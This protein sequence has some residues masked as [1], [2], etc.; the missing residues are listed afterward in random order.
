MSQEP[1]RL[2]LKLLAAL[3]VPL[4]IF[5]L[6]EVALRLSPWDERLGPQRF[7]GLRESFPLFWDPN[8]LFSSQHGEDGLDASPWIKRVKLVK[9][10]GTFRV[11]SLGG[12]V[13]YGWP[14]EKTPEA[15]YPMVLERLLNQSPPPGIRRFEVINAGVAAFS[16]YQGLE[17]F[18][19]RLRRYKPDLVTIC[20]GNND[21]EN[22]S[23]TGTFLTDREYYERLRVLA[24]KKMIRKTRDMLNSLRAYALL[25]KAVFQIKLALFR[26]QHRVPP[27]EFQR[28]LAEFLQMAQE[29]GFKLMLIYEPMI[30]FTD[31]LEDMSAEDRNNPYRKAM[32][33]VAVSSPDR[34]VL[35]NSVAFFQ[36]HQ[37]EGKKLF[38]DFMHM[39]KKGNRLMAGFLKE[40]LIKSDF[41]K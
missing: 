34:V 26:D 15:A 9:P 25:E 6:L 23:E 18:K 30:L 8:N 31:P 3:C 33:S 38:V 39:T 16:S 21:A 28:N 22:N 11:I 35:A 4:L 27:D 36:T 20:F 32:R 37:G 1:S 2:H 14:Y 24:Q 41:L 17:Y 5:G 12:S 10:P 29:D 40:D 19:L 7:N 13:T